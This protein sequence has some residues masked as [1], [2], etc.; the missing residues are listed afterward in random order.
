MA[1]SSKVII[2]TDPGTD[3]AIALLMALEEPP[4]P[5]QGKGTG[6]PGTGLDV[7]GITTVGGNASLDHTTRNALAVLEYIGRTDI[8]VAKGAAIPLGGDFP[9]AYHVHGP[10]GLSVDLPPPR[11]GPVREDA[12]QFLRDRLSATPAEATIIA[13]GPL[14]NIARLLRERPDIAPRI[15][16]LVV[17]GGAVGVQG[18]VTRY[19]EFNIFSDPLA[20]GEV[21]SSGIDITLIDLN[22]CHQAYVTR[23]EVEPL[24]NGGK[25]GQLAG[26][27]LSN[28]FNQDPDRERYYLYDPLAMAVAME[29]DIVTTRSGRLTVEVG[30]HDRIGETV[31]KPGAGN[32]QVAAEVDTAKFFE[33]FYRSLA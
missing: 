3:D 9:Y 29:P 31:F 11:T 13:L 32:V 33:L 18:N 21:F 14:T 4:L 19:A 12:V 5:G 10:E 8:P 1:N 22:A 24:L 27:I 16:S 23:R 25:G 2:D 28:W 6:P 20:A 15:D 30:S 26:R 7:V 17:M